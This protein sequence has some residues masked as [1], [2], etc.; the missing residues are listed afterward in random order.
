[1]DIVSLL[2]VG[3]SATGVDDLSAVY[4]S[5]LNVLCRSHNGYVYLSAAGDNVIPVDEVDMREK[6]EVEF[7]VL[8]GKRFASSKEHG[9][10]M[11]VGVHTRIVTG[12][13]YVSAVLSVYRSR[14]TV[15]MLLGKVGYH[16]SHNIK[17]VVLPMSTT[18]LSLVLILR[19]IMQT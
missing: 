1:M 12:L 14:M 6:A 16:L 19:Q 5:V 3:K 7:A 13:V 15:L 4:L 2:L 11:S 18:Q 8:D 10:E 9:T 17:K